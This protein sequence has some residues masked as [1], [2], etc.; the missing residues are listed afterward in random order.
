MMPQKPDHQ[1]YAFIRVL[2]LTLLALSPMVGGI[3]CA[4]T[5]TGP[6]AP[7]GYQFSL[8]AYPSTIQLPSHLSVADPQGYPTESTLTVKVRNA[9]GQP[10][11]G[12]P[13]SFSLPSDWNAYASLIPQRVL[14][15]NGVAEAIL[16]ATTSGAVKVTAQV[17]NQTREVFVSISSPSSG[18]PGSGP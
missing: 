1:A 4:P 18:P 9:Q 12:V 14:T 6:T 17:E 5:F 13:V 10:V 3:A 8:L 11:D 2:T 15:Q 7:S 16:Q